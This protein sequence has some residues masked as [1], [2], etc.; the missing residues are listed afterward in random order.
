MILLSNLPYLSIVN[1][2]P[3]GK[4]E[5]SKNSQELC[6]AFKNGNKRYIQRAIEHLQNNTDVDWS[7]FLNKTV[8]LVPVPKGAAFFV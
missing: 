8:T 5:L 6:Y 3:R 2:S 4:S 7:S 1:Y